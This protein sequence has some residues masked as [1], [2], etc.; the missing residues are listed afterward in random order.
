MQKK[1]D[2]IQ[3]TIPDHEFSYVG[4]GNYY[5]KC[6]LEQGNFYTAVWKKTMQYYVCPCCG[7]KCKK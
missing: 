3:Y 4:Q 5:V 2:E 7:L 1:I 6:N